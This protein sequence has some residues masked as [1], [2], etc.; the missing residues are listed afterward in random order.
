MNNFNRKI[1]RGSYRNVN[2]FPPISNQ[3]QV[4][5]T[6]PVPVLNQNPTS[7]EL[8]ESNSTWF[9][10]DEKKKN[11]KKVRF[12]PFVQT[13]TIHNRDYIDGQQLKKELWW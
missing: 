4:P 9:K 11:K 5:D 8:K 2:I 10:N 13:Q 3:N 6:V 1:I 12:L 7:R